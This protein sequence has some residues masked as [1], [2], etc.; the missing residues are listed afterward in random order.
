M[1]RAQIRSDAPMA[2][3]A[4]DIYLNDHLGGATLGSDLAGQIHKRHGDSALG[5]LMGR[6]AREIEEDRQTLVDLMERMDISQNPIKQAT[7][8]IAE[9]AA[10]AKFSGMGSGEAGQSDFMAIE[11][12]TLGVAG[13]GED[14]EG[15]QRGPKPLPGTRLDRPPRATRACDTAAHLARARTV[16]DRRAGFGKQRRL[17]L[18]SPSVQLA[19][20][21]SRGR[22]LRRRP[23]PRCC[24]W[25]IAR[26]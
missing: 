9:K 10:H 24:H 1:E 16:G 11:T 19:P 4:I 20:L 26:H 18:R 3:R 5:E 8:W 21:R 7:G 25:P 13:K 12:L 15:P 2:D 6:L 23:A 17:K 22:R 14:V